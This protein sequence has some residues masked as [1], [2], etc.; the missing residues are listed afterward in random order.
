MG[1]ESQRIR[2]SWLENAEAWSTAVREGQIESRRLVTDAAIIAAIVDQRPQTLLDLGCGE[3]WLVRTVAALGVIAT[4]VDASEPLIAAARDAGGGEFLVA[5]YE[6]LIERRTSFETSFDVVVANFAL[7][8]DTTPAILTALTK[9]VAPAGRVIV[10]TTHPMMT[11]ADHPYID[12]WRL[13]TFSNFPGN[14]RSPMPWYFRT[15]ESWSGCFTR[16]GYVISDIREPLHPGT[17]RPA[18]LIIIAEPP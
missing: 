9:I 18:S 15:I 5:S 14:W 8:D 7:L 1:D 10:Q 4:G 6:D 13:E 3:G 16:A 11:V 17:F 2:E 12:G